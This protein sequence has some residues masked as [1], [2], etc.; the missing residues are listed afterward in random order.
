[1]CIAESP[2]YI[3]ENPAYVAE[4]PGYVVEYPACVAQTTIHRCLRPWCGICEGTHV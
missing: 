3:V 1:V 4:S 2:G